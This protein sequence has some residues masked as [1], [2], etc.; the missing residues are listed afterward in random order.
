MFCPNCGTQ[1]PEGKKF[2][3]QCGVRL[4]DL[5]VQSNLPVNKP[6]NNQLPKYEPEAEIVYEPEPEQFPYK[7]QTPFLRNTQNE[8]SVNGKEKDVQID[9]SSYKNEPTGG[10]GSERGKGA[11]TASLVL[12]IVSVACWFF[13]AGSFIGLL[14]GIIGMICASNA[15]K[16]GFTGGIQTAG[17]VLS[18]IGTIGSA[19]VF[20][21][22]VACV[23]SLGA[24]G[25]SLGSY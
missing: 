21:A 23:G 25:G 22:C 1:L 8:A 4:E 3:R 12:G 6:E 2:C 7:E 9:D 5:L 11:A 15:K 17:F 16:E 24:L 10:N 13:G 19:F 18:L 20:I 14:T